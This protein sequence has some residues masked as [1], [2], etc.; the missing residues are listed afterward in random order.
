MAAQQA[1]MHQPTSDSAGDGSFD[2]AKVEEFFEKVAADQAVGVAAVLAYIGDR[3]GL[4]AALAPAGPVTPDQLA[5]LTGLHARYLA[6][7]LAAQAAVGYV[8][9]DPETGRFSLPPEHAMVLA[10][11]SS[12]TA[13]AGGFEFQ[14]GCWADADRVAEAFRSGQGLGWGEHDPRLLDGV[15]RFFRPLYAGSLVSEWLPALDGVVAKLERGCRVLDIG[16]GYGVSTILMAEAFPRSTFHGIDP[17]EGSLEQARTEAAKAGVADRVTFELASA[18]SD[19]GDGWDLI[20]FF[21]A[22]HHIGHPAGA[23]R[24]AL[25]ALADDGTLMLVEPLARDRLEDNLQ[26]AGSIYYSPS[27]LICVPDALAQPGGVALGAQA[28]PER[29]QRVLTDAGFTNV[30]LAQETEFNV[31]IEARR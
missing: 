10:D 1:A 17:H 30:R 27:T 26:A 25:R 7:W 15:A 22:F 19:L 29:L 18:E 12:P 4:W 20:C 5:E 3:L 11:D 31:V 23:A 9:Y 2:T 21:D 16:V 14:A 6:E 13:S 28:G 24:R 8:V